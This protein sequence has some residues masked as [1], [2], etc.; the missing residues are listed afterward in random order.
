MKIKNTSGT[1]AYCFK[2]DGKLVGILPGAIVEVPRSQ[3]DTVK[4]LVDKYAEAPETAVFVEVDE[5][6]KVSPPVQGLEETADEKAAR[7]RLEG[8][9][10]QADEKRK[11]AEALAAQKVQE[12]ARLANENAKKDA[13]PNALLTGADGKPIP[14]LK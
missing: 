7:E 9:Q 11:K 2:Q 5:S 13:P 10:A 3:V 4:R 1:F 14:L 8:K 12:D 6:A